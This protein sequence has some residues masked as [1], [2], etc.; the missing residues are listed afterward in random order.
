MKILKSLSILFDS[1]IL[2]L[3]KMCGHVI[4]ILQNNEHPVSGQKDKVE[5]PDEEAFLRDVITPIYDVIAKVI[6]IQ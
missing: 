5:A 2:S 6:L 3:P 1:W 4:G